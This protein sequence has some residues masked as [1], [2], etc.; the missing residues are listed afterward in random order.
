MASCHIP[1]VGIDA[2]GVG[3]RAPTL[4]IESGEAPAQE[5]HA[6]QTDYE[7]DIS[8]DHKTP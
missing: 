4:A 5:R 7:E 6:G 1:I 8:L 3:F 2:D